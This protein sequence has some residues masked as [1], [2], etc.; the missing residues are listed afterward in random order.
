MTI[1][2]KLSSISV[3]LWGFCRLDGFISL[4]LARFSGSPTLVNGVSVKSV[5]DDGVEH[6]AEISVTQM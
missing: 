4:R 6:V 3:H 1:S 5:Y 2:V